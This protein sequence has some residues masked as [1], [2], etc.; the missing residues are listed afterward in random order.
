[1][2]ICCDLRYPAM[3]GYVGM[4]WG[5][6][7]TRA[8]ISKIIHPGTFFERGCVVYPMGPLIYCSIEPL[9][10]PHVLIVGELVCLLGLRGYT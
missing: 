10:L 3:D 6:K 9:N 5:Q 4:A 1:M 8:T 2:T 7:T